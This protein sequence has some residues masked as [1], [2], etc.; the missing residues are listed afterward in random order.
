MVWSTVS[1]AAHRSRRM[2]IDGYPVSAVICTYLTGISQT[3]Y[4]HSVGHEAERSEIVSISLDRKVRFEM[5]L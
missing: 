5:G 1:E 4:C 3:G 2:S